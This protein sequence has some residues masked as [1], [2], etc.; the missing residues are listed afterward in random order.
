[1]SIAS[2]SIRRLILAELINSKTTVSTPQ[3]PF[4]GGSGSFVRTG[5]KLAE[6]SYII[7]VGLTLQQANGSSVSLQ[8]DTEQATVRSGFNGQVAT[9]RLL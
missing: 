7:G 4:I 2:Y 5:Q 9:Q 1:M 8:L 3:Q 6:D